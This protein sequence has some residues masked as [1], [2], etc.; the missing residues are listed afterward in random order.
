[1][2]RFIWDDVGQRTY[3]SGVDRVVLYPGVSTFNWF[4]PVAWNGVI[5]ITQKPSG[6]YSSPLYF[7]GI[8]YSE[9]LSKEEFEGTIEAFSAPRAFYQV[10]GNV[11]VISSGTNSVVPGLYAG[12]QSKDFFNL[13]WRTFNGNDVDG[14]ESSYKIHILYNVLSVPSQKTYAT[15]TSSGGVVVQSWDLKTVPRPENTSYYDFSYMPTSYFVIESGQVDPTWLGYL[16]ESMYGYDDPIDPSNSYSGYCPT[17]E[18]LIW[19]LE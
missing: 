9:G 6:G 12:Y 15:M 14:A 18:E 17:Q 1:M 7:D 8:K 2:G 16:E 13:S 3:E 19:Y 4:D 5:S 10:N 11:S